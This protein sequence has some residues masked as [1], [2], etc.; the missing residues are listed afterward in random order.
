MKQF[1]NKAEERAVE[2]ELVF[3]REFQRVCPQD[4]E[5]TSTIGADGGESLASAPRAV[6]A[7]RIIRPAW[8]E[9]EG[10][11]GDAVP[12]TGVPHL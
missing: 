12:C 10:G 1:V 2:S 5:T 4:V 8:P 6:S 11:S 9:S 3:L 7:H